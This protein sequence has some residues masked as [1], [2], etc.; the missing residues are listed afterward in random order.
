MRTEPLGDH[1]RAL[2]LNGHAQSVHVGE[3]RFGQTARH[4]RL[5]EHHLFSR[6]LQGFP[7]LD[8]TLQRAQL[9][10]RETTG[11]LALEPLQ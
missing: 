11:V 10:V 5:R 6:P 1:D 4:M 2:S 8:P 3:V 9:A 7:D